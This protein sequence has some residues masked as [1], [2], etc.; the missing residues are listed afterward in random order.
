MATNS[1]QGSIKR[2]IVGS[3][4]A[5]VTVIDE[6]D[7]QDE[8]FILFADADSA[9][10][11]RVTQSMWLSLC[12]DAILNGKRISVGTEGQNSAQISVLTLLPD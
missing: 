3:T 1:A 7:K 10:P 6:E 2:L 5:K 8:T 9:I 11:D 12:R 4:F